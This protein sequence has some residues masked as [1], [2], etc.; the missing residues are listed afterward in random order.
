MVAPAR[1]LLPGDPEDGG[2]ACRSIATTGP[3]ADLPVTR[4]DGAGVYRNRLPGCARCRNLGVRKAQVVCV[5]FCGKTAV[6]RIC[7]AGKAQLSQS[8]RRRETVGGC[9]SVSGT[10]KACR[11]CRHADWSA[12]SH[13]QS[14]AGL[15]LERGAA[16]SACLLVLTARPSNWLASPDQGGTRV[17]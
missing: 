8:D 14:E 15:K 12:G 6:R 1:V 10:G 5:A 7:G 3:E 9:F 17:Y 16:P 11:T 4:D 13:T 2:R